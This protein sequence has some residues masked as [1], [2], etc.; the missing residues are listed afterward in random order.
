MRCI[1]LTAHILTYGLFF[2]HALKLAVSSAGK[3]TGRIRKVMGLQKWD[4]PPLSPR[5][6][7]RRLYGAHSIMF[8]F[9]RFFLVMLRIVT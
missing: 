3:T 8:L 2:N 4:G 6:V 7:W 1:K 9:V 5:Q